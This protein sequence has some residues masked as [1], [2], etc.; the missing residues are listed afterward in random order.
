MQFN[1][2]EHNDLLEVTGNISYILMLWNIKICWKSLTAFQSVTSSRSLCFTALLC[3][4]CCQWLPADRY[5]SQCYSVWNVVSDFQQIFMFHS[6]TLYEMLS[7]TSSRSLCFTALFC[8]KCC[9]WL[10]ADRYVSQRYSV[11]NVVSDFQQIF[12]FHD[13]TLYEMLSVTSSVTDNI[14]YRVM[15]WNIKICWKL[16]T[17]FHTE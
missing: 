5:V 4:K 8:T 2:V 15:L 6:I 1:A 10:P 17:T 3:V 16:L 14:S 13:I 12:M 9:Q 11:C 7:V